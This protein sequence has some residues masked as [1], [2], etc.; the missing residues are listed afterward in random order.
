MGRPGGE[1][2]GERR[3]VSRYSTRI[4]ELLGDHW[5]ALLCLALVLIL[6]PVVP[7]FSSAANL[8]N[9]FSSLLPLLAVAVGQTLVLSL[10]HI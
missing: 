9:V 3:G 2:G 4:R 1:A 6:G 7:G 10:I 8:R 5:V